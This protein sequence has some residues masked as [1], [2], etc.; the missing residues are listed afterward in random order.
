M[1]LFRKCRTC[2]KVYSP[3]KAKTAD[4]SRC[5]LCQ[6]TPE[7]ADRDRCNQAMGNLLKRKR[8]KGV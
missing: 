3:M 6:R 8:G 5:Y 1:A 2:G 7:Q 4:R